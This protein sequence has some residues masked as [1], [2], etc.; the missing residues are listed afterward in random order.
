MC[1]WNSNKPYFEKCL[2][3]IVREVP[4]HHFIAVDSFSTDG[5][6]DVIKKYFPDAVIITASL[7]LANKRRLGISYVD[8]QIFAFVDDDV[9]LSKGWLKTLMLSLQENNVGAVQGRAFPSY[10]IFKHV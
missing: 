3:S 4:I 2:R 8:T 5:T 7:D 10:T 6:V 9:V 1:T